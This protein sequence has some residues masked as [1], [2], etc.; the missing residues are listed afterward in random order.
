MFP[1]FIG[2]EDAPHFGDKAWQLPRELRPRNRGLCV[3][4]QLLADEIVERAFHAVLFPDPAGRRALIDPDILKPPRA[5]H[6]NRPTKATLASKFFRTASRAPVGS[7]RTARSTPA[8]RY[9]LSR[10]RSCGAAKT[11]M[12][13]SS[14]LRLASAAI[15]RNRGKISSASRPLPPIGIHPLPKA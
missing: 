11:L 3:R 14:G 1:N 2:A 10:S 12:G 13:T 6:A 5:H 15:C 7:I 8:S 9:R 4:H